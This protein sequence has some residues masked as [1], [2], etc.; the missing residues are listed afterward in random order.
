MQ[1]SVFHCLCCGRD[2]PAKYSFRAGSP[3]C[4]TCDTLQPHELVLTTRATAERELSAELAKKRSSKAQRIIARL[5]AYRL[6]GKRCSACHA[7]KDPSEFNA[8]IPTPDGLQPV[9]RACNALRVTILKSGA[10]LG[11]WHIVRDALRGASLAGGTRSA[12]PAS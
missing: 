9:C 1:T 12:D 3:T 5:E 4:R 8:C 2:L 7:Q 11:Q 6:T 10:G